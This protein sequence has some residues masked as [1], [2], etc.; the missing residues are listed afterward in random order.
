M[1][2]LSYWDSLYVYIM[3][4]MGRADSTWF[5]I[6]NIQPISHNICVIY[7]KKVLQDRSMECSCQAPPEFK[8]TQ[9][10][11]LNKSEEWDDEIAKKGDYGGLVFNFRLGRFTAKNRKWFDSGAGAS[12]VENS[13]LNSFCLN[14]PIF[15]KSNLGIC[16]KKPKFK[17]VALLRHKLVKHFRRAN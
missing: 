1:G 10:D 15:E 12:R 14:R 5:H 7:A 4:S 11:N 3:N 13:G 17:I 9:L 6:N 16:Q 8:I 2:L